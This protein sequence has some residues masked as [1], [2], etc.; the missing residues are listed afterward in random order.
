[1]PPHTTST[2]HGARD[3]ARAMAGLAADAMPT[4]PSSSAVDLP[5]GVARRRRAVGRDGRR[6]RLHV[7]RPPS[8][9]AAPHRGRR[10][11]R[12]RGRAPASGR[13]PRRAPQRRGHREGAVAGLPRVRGP[14]C[15]P[16][17]DGCWPPIV[18]DT[19]GRHDALCGTST[20]A[21]Q[22]GAATARATSTGPSP[23]GRDRFAVA[24]LKHGLHRRDVAPE[25]QPVQGRAGR[26]RR[27]A[28]VRRCPTAG[29]RTS[30]S[31][32]SCPSSSPSWPRPTPLDPRPRHHATRLRVTAW[33][34][35]PSRRRMTPS[36]WRLPKAERAYLNTEQ[37]V[38]VS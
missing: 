5:P 7:G 36:D 11:R 34:G 15:C 16:T 22:R 27:L 9:S 25:H 19:S 23:N 29:A 18:E 33:R 2:T 10:G 30:R 31:A 21:R 32:P 3:H 14:C 12:L 24:L 37:A 8:G 1:M 4:V 35:A 38:L 13:P 17:W 20:R 26:A 6:R 28:H